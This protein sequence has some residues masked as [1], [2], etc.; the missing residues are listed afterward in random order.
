MPSTTP[1]SR[2]YCAATS[3]RPTSCSVTDD[4][5]D[6]RILLADSGIARNLDNVSGLTATNM[7]VGTVAYAAPEQLMG[8]DIDGRAD[9]CAL[10]A[11][12]YHLLTGSPLYPHPNPAVVI[13]RHLNSAPPAL[14]DNQPG[15][16]GLDP[17]L[18]AALA[19]NPDDRFA[20]CADFALA[21]AE[22]VGPNVP[23]TAAPRA[24][25]VLAASAN[26]MPPT[27]HREST[28]SPPSTEHRHVRSRRR[29][30]MPVCRLPG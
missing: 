18:A 10:A 7:T 8:E 25:A 30:P 15:L 22:Q 23:A 27:A 21:F 2:V 1:T 13:S 17:V 19:K 29:W 20:R 3:N 5:G 11:T 26:P 28:P 4:H 24:R 12:A 6:K 16:A 14:A 9:Q